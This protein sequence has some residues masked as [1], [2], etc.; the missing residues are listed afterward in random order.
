MKS[1]TTDELLHVAAELHRSNY[2][3]FTVSDLADVLRLSHTEFK[4]RA[5]IAAIRARIKGAISV[6]LLEKTDRCYGTNAEQYRVVDQVARSRRE[7]ECSAVDNLAKK[8]GGKAEHFKSGSRL[9]LTLEQA[10][11]LVARLAR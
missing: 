1:L 6:G 4:R 9:V 10:Q 7:A 2:E 8:L 11:A 5:V 3:S